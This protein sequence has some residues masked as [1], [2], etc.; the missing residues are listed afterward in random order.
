MDDRQTTG[1]GQSE[2]IVQCHKCGKEYDAALAP[3]CSC[4]TNSRSPQCPACGACSCSAPK[5]YRDKFWSDAPQELCRRRFTEKSLPFASS[6]V[7]DSRDLKRPLILVADDERVI[8]R[9]ASKLL[10]DMGFTVLTAKD[11]AQALKMAREHLPDLLLTDALMP[12]MDGREVCKQLKSSPQTSAI[13]VIV[14][15]SAYTAPKY[16]TEAL[17]AYRADEYVIKPVD[18]KLLSALLKKLL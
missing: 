15:T 16:K 7:P 8:L 1:P 5:A 12:K 17:S 18:F 9:L 3:W 13:K 10:G 14:M 4:I 11:G 6:V 2:Y